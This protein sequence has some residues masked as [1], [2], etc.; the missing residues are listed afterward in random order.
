[1]V[2]IQ[3]TQEIKQKAIQA[4]TDQVEHAY[5]R[6]GFDENKRLNQFIIGNIGELAFESFL[7]NRLF[8]YQ[9]NFVVGLA[10]QYDFIVNGF[11]I[12][13]KTSAFYNNYGFQS[14]NL[15]YSED[16][17][18]TG[19]KKG[20]NFCTVMMIE[21]KTKAGFDIDLCNFAYM[22]GSIKYK[23]IEKYKQ[24]PRFYGDDYRVPLGGLK[25]K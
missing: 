23:D 4:A 1:M 5:N 15:L 9:Y 24:K 20:F 8:D 14:L 12:E 25:S 18:K 17:Y 2:K 10:D 6:F 16:Q 22:V 7:I 13:V 21:G 19:L 3:V 11:K